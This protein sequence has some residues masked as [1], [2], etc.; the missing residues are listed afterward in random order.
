MLVSTGIPEIG[1]GS[2]TALLL[3]AADV[4]GIPFERITMQYGDTKAGPFDIGSHATRTLYTVSQVIDKAGAELKRVIFWIMQL[5][6][7]R[8]RQLPCPWRDRSDLRRRKID[9]SVEAGIRGTS[10]RKTVYRFRQYGSAKLPSM[11]C[12]DC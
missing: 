4:M 1:P 3:V 10:E 11:V 7:L 6:S 12:P 5:S 2:T 9:P 8:W